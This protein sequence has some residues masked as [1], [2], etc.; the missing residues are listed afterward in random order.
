MGRPV[1]FEIHA[2]DPQR[3]RGF[4]EQVFGWTFQQ[5]GEQ[6]YW[7]VTTGEEGLPGINGGLL[8]RRGDAPATGAPVNSFVVTV[9]VADLDETLGTAA[10]A[11]GEIRVPRTPVPGIGWLAYLADPDGNLFGVMQNDPSAPAPG[12]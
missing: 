12:A 7:L 3:S 5:W 8:P 2:T 1:H 6:P 10:K 4:Y 9:D 11:G